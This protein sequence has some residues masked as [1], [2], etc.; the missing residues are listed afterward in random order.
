MAIVE[1]DTEFVGRDKTGKAFEKL[2]AWIEAQLN[3][4]GK[5]TPNDYIQDQQVVGIKCKRQCDVTIWTQSA[6]G[7]EI[8]T[9]VEVRARGK[10]QDIQWLDEVATKKAAVGAHRTILVSKTRFSKAA[11]EKA[12]FHS[13]ELRT[14]QQA[15][16]EDWVSWLDPHFRVVYVGPLVTN[17]KLKLIDQ[18]CEEISFTD[19]FR[20]ATWND[21]TP[22]FED[23]T[24]VPTVS[25]AEV[26]ANVIAG[27]KAMANVAAN[28][29]SPE[30]P[31]VLAEF[32]V[33]IDPTRQLWLRDREGTRRRLR[34]VLLGAEIS[35]IVA[36][37][38]G[39]VSRLRD[40]LT[41]RVVSEDVLCVLPIGEQ[42]EIHARV[43]KEM[44]G[45][46]NAAFTL[47]FQLVKLGG[48]R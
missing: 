9:L 48:P 30:E 13:V 28:Q 32:G 19:E 42:R 43:L 24:G 40:I 34:A 7:E 10:G 4:Y 47:N 45:E 17:M 15:V 14:Y 39:K 12:K 11:Q 1:V 27:L 26:E 6:T 44:S 25:R 16:K 23:E 21:T 20:A 46:P 38:Q 3:K 41:G 31:P 2:V 22:I 35:K 36:S 29:M 37:T 5:V 8:L 33:D 18:H